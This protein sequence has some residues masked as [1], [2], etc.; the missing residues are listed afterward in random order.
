[1]DII[2]IIGVGLTGA[3]AS[4]IVKQTRPELAVVLSVATAAILFF[5]VSGK[6]S[7]LF[8]FFQ[9]ITERLG[10]ESQPL[11]TVIRAI[12]VAYLTQ[13]GADLC[14]DAGQTAI[15]T[16]IE[17]AGKALILAMAT[18]I[19]AALIQLLVGMLPA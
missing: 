6:L 9:G 8:A 13:L 14:R 3:I 19:L 7:E 10:G 5:A 15:A 2:K 4:L 17:I 1:M 18:P 16:K 12:G 11:F